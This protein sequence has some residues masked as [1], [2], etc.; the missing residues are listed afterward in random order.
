MKQLEQ[1]WYRSYNWLYI[2]P[3]NEIIKKFST[4]IW[5]IIWKELIRLYIFLFY[6]LFTLEKTNK[7]IYSV[8]TASSF[9]ESSYTFKRI[10]PVLVLFDCAIPTLLEH[11]KLPRRLPPNLQSEKFQQKPIELVRLPMTRS[12]PNHSKFKF[13]DLTSVRISAAAPC[14]WVTSREKNFTIVVS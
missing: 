11:L 1:D 9:S 13:K 10:D 4:N 3:I 5:T 8:V 14:L 7:N 12:T 6:S 2:Y